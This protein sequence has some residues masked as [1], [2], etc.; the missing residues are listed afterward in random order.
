M[1]G[2]HVPSFPGSDRLGTLI[3]AVLLPFALTQVLPPAELPIRLTLGDFFLDSSLTLIG[4]MTLLAA[5]VTATGMD[6]LI[7]SHPALHARQ[8][9]EHWLVP[10][11]TT[12]VLG[13]PL[14]ILPAGHS[15]WLALGLAGLLLAV[16]FLAEYIT[17]DPTAPAYSVAGGLLTALSFAIFLILVSALR[18]AGPRLIFFAP[19]VALA[20]FLIPVRALRLRLRRWEFLWPLGIAWITV[21]LAAAFH[22]WPLSPLQHG[23]ALLG[24]L[25]ALTSLAIHLSENLS[26]RR[27]AL[28]PILAIVL[29]GI[30]ILV[31][32]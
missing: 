6:W 29:A 3:A 1:K 21:Q 23:L 19:A 32:R 5:G 31:L 20:S 26:W 11:L 10:T 22:Y 27:A 9:V 24:P 13:I 17:V 28:E 15:W 14:A 4:V 2:M 16:V 8:T 7:R 25:Y 30:A 18:A 12:L